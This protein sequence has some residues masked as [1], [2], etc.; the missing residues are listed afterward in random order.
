MLKKSDRHNRYENLK[1]GSIYF[2]QEYLQEPLFVTSLMGTDRVY[3]SV[4]TEG[5]YF[6]NNKAYIAI[7]DIM[8]PGSV[9]RVGNCSRY[10]FLLKKLVSRDRGKNVYEI[11]LSDQSFLLAL[12]T[13]L[14][15]KN[16][17][18]NWIADLKRKDNGTLCK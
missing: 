9:F 13:E 14:L 8:Y 2:E 1:Q 10:E 6:K 17:R 15:K 12:H 3:K 16:A 5:L 7:R 18:I 4:I 11:I